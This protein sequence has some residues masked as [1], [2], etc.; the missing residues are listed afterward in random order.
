MCI[1]IKAGNRRSTKQNAFYWGVV[2]EAVKRMFEDAGQP[3]TPEEV[4]AYLKEHVAGMVKV[5][6]VGGQRKSIVESSTKL[7]KGEWEEYIEKIRAWGA[8][9]GLDIPEPTPNGID[10]ALFN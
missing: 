1:E 5:I 10:E 2:I 8:P 6:T 9:Y 3:V 4:H 7:T